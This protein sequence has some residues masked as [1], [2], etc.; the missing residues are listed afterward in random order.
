MNKM[1]LHLIRRVITLS[2]A[3]CRGGVPGALRSLSNHRRI[4]NANSKQEQEADP[5]S[6]EK[7]RSSQAKSSLRR[8]GAAA[9][10][11]PTAPSTTSNQSSLLNHFFPDEHNKAANFATAYC[12]A[13]KYDLTAAKRILKRAGYIPDPF[14]TGLTDQ[15]IHLRIGLGSR[16]H[17]SV[18]PEPPKSV[19]IEDSIDAVSAAPLQNPTSEATKESV[20]NEAF[21]SVNLQS[22]RSKEK[23]LAGDVFI[24]SSGNIVSWSVPE[25]SITRLA[26]TISKSAVGAPY[27]DEIET[28][29]LEFIVDPTSRRS[30][31]RGD[32]IVL[33]IDPSVSPQ[34][35]VLT[36][37]AFSSGLARS[38]KLAWLEDKLNSYLETTRDIPERLSRGGRLPFQRSFILRKTGELLRFRAA[39][40]LY[41][42]LT[43]SLPDIF[44]D[45]RHELGLEG[46]YESVGRALDI[47]TRIG[48]LNKK[49]DYATEIVGVLRE[50]LS[51]LQG[52]WLEWMIIILIAVEV[53]FEVMRQWKERNAHLKEEEEERWRKMVWERA[54]EDMRQTWEE[55]RKAKMLEESRKRKVKEEHGQSIGAAVFD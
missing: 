51:E 8:A 54:M 28:E 13:D 52:L 42:E 53:G 38:T 32:V 46:Y 31:V 47:E 25:T 50:R 24:F 22:E 41:S 14:R 4:S 12:T 3:G 15:V 44:W 20:T 1:T 37:I 17:T 43:D 19:P 27:V 26:T 45:S 2:K 49:L 11:T 36:K 33:G 55:E 16:E 29:D 48:Q 34:A 40:N 30:Y 7:K 39:L 21:D 9:S 6:F 5:V 35:L 23:E 18:P 10:H